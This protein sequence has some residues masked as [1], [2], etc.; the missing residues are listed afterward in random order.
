MR[1]QSGSFFNPAIVWYGKPICA[2]W[3]ETTNSCDETNVNFESWDVRKT[4]GNGAI[5]VWVETSNTKSGSKA[6]RYYTQAP[7]PTN[8]SLTYFSDY[9]PIDETKY[10]EAG[11]WSYPI[12]GSRD[13]DVTLHFYDE[14]K[15]FLA[16]RWGKIKRVPSPRVHG[17]K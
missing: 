17:K 4:P 13:Y 15:N 2:Y 12:Q 11:F 9:F 10:Y 6:L 14:N 8:L 7:S 1:F 5:R 16:R 3:N